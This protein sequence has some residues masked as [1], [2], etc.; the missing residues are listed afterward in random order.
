MKKN[1]M[2]YGF[3]SEQLKVWFAMACQI[4]STGM[5]EEDYAV[6]N[7]IILFKSI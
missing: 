5:H 7:N 6:L 2:K 4:S 3:M 1:H